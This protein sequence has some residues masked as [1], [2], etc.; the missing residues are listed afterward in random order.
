MTNPRVAARYAKAL[1]DL[2]VEKNQL[3]AVYKDSQ[4][5]QSICK[6]NREFLTLIKSPVVKPYKKNAI[7]S[8]ILDGKVTV[9]TSSFI[10]LLVNKGRESVLPEILTEVEAYYNRINKIFKV[11]FTTAV[12]ISDAIKADIIS[13]IK[14]HRAAADSIVLD[15]VIDENII[16]GF[17]LELGD[18]LIDGSVEKDLKD[19]KRQFFKN[20]YIF[21][22]R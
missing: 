2:G 10:K 19:I 1:V 9:I 20:E 6:S 8:A 15:H 11:K 5:I 13:K 12:E 22:I 16:G 7:L 14:D 18:L 21:N 3:E 17:K 4:L